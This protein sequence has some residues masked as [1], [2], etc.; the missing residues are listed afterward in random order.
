MATKESDITEKLGLKRIMIPV[1]IGL[2]VATYLLVSNLNEVRFEEVPAGTGQYAWIDENGDGV[3]DLKDE[4]EFTAQP[5]GDYIRVT[6]QEILKNIDWT[7]YSAFWFFMALLCVA[8]RDL[9]YMYRIRILTDKALTWRK[10]FDTIMLWEFA[11]ALTPSIVGGSGVALFILNREGIKMGKSTA[12]VMVTALMDELFYI[13]MVPVVLLLI[14]TG[15]LFPVSL[16]KEILGITFGTQGLF[17]LGYFFIVTLTTVIALAIFFR[18]RLFKYI[19]LQ[20]FRLPFL[21]RWRYD[22]IALGNDII[23]TSRELK[24]KRPKFWIQAISATYFSWTARFIVVNLLILAVVPV[25]DHLLLYGRQLVM[26]VIMLISP[27]PGSSGLAEFAFTGFLADF[28]PLGLAGGLAFIWR[29]LTYY[30]YIFIGAIVLPR[31]LRRTRIEL[32][33]R[34]SRVKPSKF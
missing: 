5:E 26:W 2:A 28:I 23:I 19:L 18:P 24:G 1:V 10:A 11:S 16:Q 25:S 27:T 15:S 3:V 31:W 9:G 30:I 17:W 34:Q 7:W 6:Y 22:I 12:V 20:I 29:I 32:A 8:A 4:A 13:T 14:G 33:R 21:K